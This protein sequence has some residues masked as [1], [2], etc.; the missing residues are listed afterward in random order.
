MGLI[1]PRFLYHTASA[2]LL[3]VFSPELIISSLMLGTF[4]APSTGT[5]DGISMHRPACPGLFIA[6]KPVA[7]LGSQ[8]V[9]MLGKDRNENCR[10]PA[11]WALAVLDA[12][13]LRLLYVFSV[14]AEEE[15]LCN[16]S[17]QR[18]FPQGSRELVRPWTCLKMA[19]G[20]IYIITW[21]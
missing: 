8:A 14:C 18:V 11:S 1:S 9:G 17:L 4:T 3:Y 21:C 6:L 5:T 19:D 7:G 15:A 16:A 12:L 10:G 2:K 13:A 20:Y